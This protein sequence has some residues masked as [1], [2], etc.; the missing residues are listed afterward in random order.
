[1]SLL[2]D[3]DIAELTR[4]KQ[5]AKQAEILRAHG[6]KYITRLDGSLTTTW[7]AVN[8][9]LAPKSGAPEGPKLDW[10]KTGS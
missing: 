2:S 5:G 3:I 4:A 8:A 1:M 10:L 9:A 7:E 6:I